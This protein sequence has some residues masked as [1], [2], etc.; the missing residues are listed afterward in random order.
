MEAATNAGV[1]AAYLLQEQQQRRVG[2]SM[3]GCRPVQVPG[4][5]LLRFSQSKAGGPAAASSVSIFAHP[6]EVKLG[7]RGA[8]MGFGQAQFAADDVG[9]FDERDAFVIGDAAAEAL[10][11]K[12]A[13]SRDDEPLGRDLFERFAD[14]YRDVVC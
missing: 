11:A 13:I 2:A 10:A 1:F 9:A 14:Q 7:V 3:H 4:A 8:D 5:R 6:G 12:A